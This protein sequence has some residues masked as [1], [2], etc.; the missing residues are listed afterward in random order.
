[1]GADTF[2]HLSGPAFLI[3]WQNFAKKWNKNQTFENEVIL[4]GFNQCVFLSSF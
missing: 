3:N 2:D 1:V 4:E